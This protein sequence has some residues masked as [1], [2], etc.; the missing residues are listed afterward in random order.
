MAIYSDVTAQSVHG[1]F[2]P[3]ILGEPVAD[4]SILTDVE[5]AASNPYNKR[6]DLCV[7]R[8]VHA[9]QP[10]ELRRIVVFIQH[11]DQDS[12]RAR[13]RRLSLVS[14]FYDQLVRS[15]LKEKA[16]HVYSSAIYPFF[17][18]LIFFD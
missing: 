3:R 11:G 8:H 1:E 17:S 7:F 10:G 6:A 5:I 2:L 14:R 9:E 13:Q 15:D 16:G 4:I 12:C 18:I